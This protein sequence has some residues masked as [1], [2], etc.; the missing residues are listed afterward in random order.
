MLAVFLALEILSNSS[1][2]GVICRM[3]PTVS[4]SIIFPFFLDFSLLV[5]LNAIFIHYVLEVMHFLCGVIGRSYPLLGV[6]P[7]MPGLH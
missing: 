2:S 7:I 6:L 3:L 4:D 1:N 5:S